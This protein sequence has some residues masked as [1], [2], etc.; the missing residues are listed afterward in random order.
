MSVSVSLRSSAAL[1]APSITNGD[2][3]Y[4]K[5]ERER[6]TERHRER[7]RERKGERERDKPIISIVKMAR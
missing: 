2:S 6:D 5:V 1:E 3:G 7:E 4:Q